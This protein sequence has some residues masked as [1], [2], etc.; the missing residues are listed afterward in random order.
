MAAE[1][2]A[3]HGEDVVT[4]GAAALYLQNLYT[5][6]EESL[7]RIAFELDGSV[8][9]GQ[10]WRRELLRQLRL[11]LPGTRPALIDDQLFADLDLLRRSGIS[12]G[13]PML[14]NTFG[15]SSCRSSRPRNG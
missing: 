10:E 8:P 5:A 11:E 9:S 13:M 1:R 15:R 12:S 14:R 6:I 4:V 2:V 7:K 3:D